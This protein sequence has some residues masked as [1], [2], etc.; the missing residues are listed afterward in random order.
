MG[1][2]SSWVQT[3]LTGSFMTSALTRARVDCRRE[4]LDAMVRLVAFITLLGAF[5]TAGCNR[6]VHWKSLPQIKSFA[7]SGPE[8][9]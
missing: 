4:Y 7:L 2:P 8:R 9:A 5:F 6:P 3:N 1:H